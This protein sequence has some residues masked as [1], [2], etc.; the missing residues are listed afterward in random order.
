MDLTLPARGDVPAAVTWDIASVYPS[1][2][3]WEQAFADAHA[4]LPRVAAYA[5][6]LGESGELLLAALQAR[7]ALGLAG[8]RLALYAAMQSATDGTDQAARARQD[9]AAS[10]QVQAAQASAS[11]EPEIL[12]LEHTHLET[13]LSSTPGL[14]AYRPYCDRLRRQQP[15]IRSAEVEAVLAAAGALADN[16]ERTFG[17]LTAADLEFAPIRDSQGA[18]IPVTQATIYPL[19]RSLDRAVRQ[20]AWES[21]G[22]AHLRIRNGLASTLAGALTRD[23]FYARARQYPSAL[24]AALAPFNIPTAVFDNLQATCQAHLPLWHRYWAICRR[25]LGVETLHVYD[26]FMPLV[27]TERRIPYAEATAIVEAGL[28]PLGEEYLAVLRRGLHEE[29]WVDIYPNQGKYGVPFSTGVHGTHPFVLHNYVEDLG[30]VS[31]LA[32]ELGHAMHSYFTWQTQP[33]INSH[34]SMFVAETASNVNQALVRAHL[35]ATAT[36][37]DWQLEILAEALENFHLYLFIMPLLA[38]F[39]LACHEQV[40][41]GE[42]LSADSLSAGLVAVFRDGYG[43]NVQIDAPRLGINWVQV[44]TLF[45]NFYAFQ[46]ATGIAAANALAAELLQAG[47]SAAARYLDFLRAGDSLDPLD[48]LQLAGVDMRTPAP[49]ERAYAVLAALIDRLDQLV[50]AG[51]LRPAGEPPGQGGA[52]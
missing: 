40:E 51:P 39:E 11:F 3:A 24:A 9:R 4:A 19:R 41:R 48:A 6:R 29:R 23:V 52:A 46:Y 43:P 27:R 22:D 45:A 1:A 21:Y 17:A 32:H 10:L 8:A 38:R 47:P 18:A 25:A 5:G 28:A 42:A 26:T 2:A 44:P 37:P 34:Y 12:A 14:Q 7:D 30:S 13:L 20:G 15:H 36:D 16:P 33:P 50:G 35:L 31:V 49:V